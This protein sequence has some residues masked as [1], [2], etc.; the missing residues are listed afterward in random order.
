MTDP[1]ETVRGKEVVIRFE[2]R[3]CIHSRHCV[4]DSHAR[5]GF[6]PA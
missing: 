6:Q 3:K 4:L 2:A 5:I 1:V